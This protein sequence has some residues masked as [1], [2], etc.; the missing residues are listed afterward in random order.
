[1]F[2]HRETGFRFSMS[3]THPSGE[4]KRYQV[5]NAIAA[6]TKVRAISEDE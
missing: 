3:K 2:E 1:M 6:L 4:L 5:K